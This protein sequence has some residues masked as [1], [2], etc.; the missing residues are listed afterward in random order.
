MRL[1]VHENRF[2]RLRCPQ[3]RPSVLSPISQVRHDSFRMPGSVMTTAYIVLAVVTAAVNFWAAIGDFLRT[4]SAMKNAATVEVPSS[5][6]VPLGLLKTAGAV[7]LL[8][9]IVI[10]V[11]GVAAAIGLCC[12]SSAP[13]SLICEWGFLSQAD[14]PVVAGGDVAS[15]RL[16]R[17]SVCRRPATEGPVSGC[18]DTLQP[19]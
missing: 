12:S 14:S 13:S 9:G 17:C 6:L 10:P 7:G 4:P 11:I 16:D 8:I 5:W 19:T 1:V 3:G 15:R 18:W 2:L